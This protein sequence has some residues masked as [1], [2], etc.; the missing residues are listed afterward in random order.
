LRM[1]RVFA[2]GLGSQHMVIEDVEIQTA[3]T[4]GKTPTSSEV[5]VLSV[6]PKTS[7]AGRCSRCRKRCRGDDARGSATCVVLASAASVTS[8]R[9]NQQI[10]EYRQ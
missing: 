6:R 10:L 3:T 9:P 8:V 7:Q 4:H 5:L 1:S 2:V